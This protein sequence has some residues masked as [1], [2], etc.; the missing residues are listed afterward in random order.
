LK[1][2]VTQNLIGKARY[3]PSSADRFFNR[4]DPEPTFEVGS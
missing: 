2:D 1:S 4:I 3:S